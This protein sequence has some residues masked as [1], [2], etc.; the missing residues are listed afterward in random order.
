MYGELFEDSPRRRAKRACEGCLSLQKN[1][2]Q[3]AP[4]GRFI[5][6]CC[7]K[8]VCVDLARPHGICFMSNYSSKATQTPGEIF[9]E[10]RHNILLHIKCKTVEIVYNNTYI[11]LTI[12]KK[13]KQ[14]CNNHSSRS[15]RK[16]RRS[17]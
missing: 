10:H 4:G 14:D 9:Y 8:L 7:L 12:W 13:L 5:S 15:A 1:Q 2:S 17:C 16:P 6:L 3:P 11:R